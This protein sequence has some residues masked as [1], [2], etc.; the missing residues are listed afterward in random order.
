MSEVERLRAENARLR[1]QLADQDRFH[2]S[3]TSVIERA[4]KRALADRD[5][6][7]RA[8]RTA[9][10]EWART[11]P[12]PKPT[13][14]VPYSQ[15]SEADQE[16]DRQIGEHIAFL[17]GAGW[18][19]E[20][21]AL[22]HQLAEQAQRLA[23]TDDEFAQALDAKVAMEDQLVEEYAGRPYDPEWRGLL[24]FSVRARLAE[25]EVDRLRAEN[26]AALERRTGEEG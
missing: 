8:V 14:L 4:G 5:E 15:L 22:Q 16:A 9:W 26:A 20:V 19:R 1:H 11:Q 10:M 17:V 23:T 2:G 24:P 6:L 13:W 12:N 21:A 3:L 25:A 18:A 7:G